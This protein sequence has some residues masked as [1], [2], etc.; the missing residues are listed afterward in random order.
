MSRAVG[1]S[2]LPNQGTARE[3]TPERFSPLA[4]Q[5]SSAERAAMSKRATQP[6]SGG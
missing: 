2:E 3:Q 6:R 4:L 5:R 1:P